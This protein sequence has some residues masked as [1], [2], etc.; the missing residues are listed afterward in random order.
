VLLVALAIGL[1]ALRGVYAEQVNLMLPLVAIKDSYGVAIGDAD[2]PALNE[3]GGRSNRRYAEQECD[4]EGYPTYLNHG[5]NSLQMMLSTREGIARGKI[6]AMSSENNNIEDLKNQYPS[7]D[8]AYPIAV[9]SYEVAAKRLDTV[10]GRLQTI[11]AFIVTV[12]V[13]VPSVAGSRGASFQ[14]PWFFAALIVFLGAIATGTYAR[15][16]GMLR[17]LKPSQLYLDWLGDPEWE[18]KKNMIHFA[19]QDFDANLRLVNFKWKCSVAVTIL[20]AAEAVCLA[21]WVAAA[22]F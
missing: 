20:F 19:G 7:V 15:L 8:L 1:V 18:F 4:Y 6:M 2:N 22:Q 17:V 10:D 9:A 14:S 3:V 5:L 21:A 16:V 13:A 12:S 11:L